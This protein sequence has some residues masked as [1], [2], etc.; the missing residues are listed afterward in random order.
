MQID[1]ALKEENIQITDFE[2]EI[3]LARQNND[4]NRLT[5]L[6]YLQ[7]SVSIEQGRTHSLVA[8]QNS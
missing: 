4:F 2:K 8:K 6:I 5:L 7:N 1:D 3:S